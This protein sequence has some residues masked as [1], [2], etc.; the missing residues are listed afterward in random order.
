MGDYQEP[1]SASISIGSNGPGPHPASKDRPIDHVEWHTASA[2]GYETSS[3]IIGEQWPGRNGQPFKIIMMGAGAAG[4]DFLHHA[5]TSLKDL[6]V[7]IKC[8]EKNPDVGGTWFENRY[9]GCACDGPSASY[10][11]PWRPNPDWTRYYSGAKEIWEYMK[12]IVMDEGLDRFIQLSTRVEK[13]VWNDERSEWI[14]SLRHDDGRVWDE[15]CNVFLNGTGFLNAWK[16]PSIPGL[17]SFEGRLF[18]TARYEEGYDLT[19]KRVAVIGSGSSGVQTVAT[20]YPQVS[21]LYTWVRSPTWITAGFAQKYAGEKGAN[22]AYS[23][24]DKAEWR[25]DPEKYRDYRRLIEGELNQRYKS[26]LRNSE[27][28]QQGNEF[29]YNEMKRKLGGDSRLVDKIIPK[30]FNVGC[31]RPTPGNGYLEALVGEKTTV[32][33]ETVAKI[34]PKGFVDQEGTEYEC[35]VIICATGFDTSYRPQF[36]VFGL[37]GVSLQERWSKVPESYLGVAAPSMPNYFMFTGPFTPVAQG[38]ILPIITKMSNYS[39][40]VIHKMYKQH[41]RRVTPKE[42]VIAEFM[43]HCRAYL[44]RTCWADPCTSWFKQGRPDGPI[45]MW[46]GSRLAFFDAV[47]TPQWEDYDI[48]YHANNRFGFLGSGFAMCEF[49]SKDQLTYYL[50]GDLANALPHQQIKEVKWKPRT[51]RTSE[52]DAFY[53]MRGPQILVGPKPHPQPTLAQIERLKHEKAVLK[54]LINTLRTASQ[55]ERDT[56]LASAPDND[57]G[58]TL[59]D[60]GMVA[61]DNPRSVGTIDESSDDEL[62]ILNFLSVDEGGKLQSFGPSSALHVATKDGKPAPQTPSTISRENARNRLVANAA[63]QRQMEHQLS[64]KS[65]ICEVPTH[66][67]IHL[68]NLHWSRQHHTFLLTY[69]PAIMR[70]LQEDGPHCSK[71]LIQA[72]FA[73]SSKFSPLLEVRDNPSNASTAGARFFRRCDQLLAEEGLLI[74]PTVPTVIGLLLLG[75]SYNARGETSKAWLYTGYALRMVY[76]LGLH[77]DPQETTDMAEEIEIRRRV[78]WGAFVCDKLQSLYLGRPVAINLRDSRVSRDFLDEFEEQELFSPQASH[79]SQLPLSGVSMPIHSVSTFQQLCLLSK[80]MTTIINRY[81]V[82]GSTFSN[83]QGSLQLVDGILSRW[84]QGLPKELNYQAWGPEESHTGLQPPNVMV[85]HSLYHSLIILL[86]RPFIS[87]GH[88]RAAATP[89]LSWERCTNAAMCLSRIVLSYKSAFG[90]IAAPYVLG[91]G[92]YVAC[93]IHVRNAATHAP[94]YREHRTL[95]ISTLH[96]LDDLTLANPGMA[97]PADIIRK[98]ISVNNVESSPEGISPPNH[99]FTDLDLDAII[100]LFPPTTLPTG[101][102]DANQEIDHTN[103]FNIP[104]DP[105]F[106]LMDLTLPPPG[107]SPLNPS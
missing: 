80:I 39:L 76:D 102:D 14:L 30:D 106:G 86:H 36:P 56:L 99:A 28:S 31:R 48:E 71:F 13:A 21:K 72:I 77:L 54:S 9:P 38:S 16:W 29:S 103:Q 107:P 32:F 11:F 19:G 61:A 70:D 87:H 82:V 75:S 93:T 57:P 7:E 34:T 3:H 104:F 41:I 24:E 101:V 66:L 105:L 49:A 27:E 15:S 95:L 26:V 47:S 43:E 10:Q 85:L 96:C 91:Y 17:H 50:D 97:K 98:M 42:C 67:A 58:I 52:R 90:L 73:C 53:A 84:K 4:I 65:H 100:N 6:D 89:V 12:G 5:T 33:T 94:N 64:F 44:G 18:H 20:I 55:E 8:F 23:E 40:Q 2:T 1:R 88:L 35:D 25:K 45:V 62:D 81:Y 92:A 74:R 69:R 51:L 68:L 22:F 46:P 79:T 59:S 60:N 83:A 37:N 63:L 78:F